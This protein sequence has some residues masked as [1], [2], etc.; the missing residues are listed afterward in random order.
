MVKQLDRAERVDRQV[1]FML[2]ALLLVCFFLSAVI[3]RFV[4]L[5]YAQEQ[6]SASAKS[7]LDHLSEQNLQQLLLEDG[8]YINDPYIMSPEIDFLIGS[9]IELSPAQSVYLVKTSRNLKTRFYDASSASDIGSIDHSY[10]EEYINQAT[11]KMMPMSTNSTVKSGSQRVFGFYY[12]LETRNVNIKSVV[13]IEFSAESY[14]RS[15]A[16]S[17]V[18]QG[19]IM[20][21]LWA[22]AALWAHSKFKAISNLGYKSAFNID[23]MTGFKN[24]NAFDIDLYNINN[25][26]GYEALTIYY[27]DLNDL[28]L[29]NDSKGHEAGDQYLRVMA[30]IIS[31]SMGAGDVI[32]RVGG[33][34]F[35]VLSFNH[36][37]SKAIA[38]IGRFEQEISKYNEAHD[39][40]YSAAI[41][42]AVFNFDIDADASATRARAE[43]RMYDNKKRMKSGLEQLAEE[44]CFVP[45][46]SI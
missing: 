39:T 31:E 16:A 23:R 24:R 37:R 17:F 6:F 29:V 25:T 14:M 3:T 45:E 9:A 28:K 27:I 1:S 26:R 38:A 4:F 35:C 11:L 12:P 33:D 42:F 46:F 43:T 22:S 13:A 8:F 7:I 30:R 15:L 32:Y 2:L 18:I 21:I 44:G 34:E 19:M 40:D 10:A 5:K 36:V 20:I 41:G